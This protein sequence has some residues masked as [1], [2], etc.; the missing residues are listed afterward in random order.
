LSSPTRFFGSKSAIL[1]LKQMRALHSPVPVIVVS[2]L[3]DLAPVREQVLANGALALIPNPFPNPFDVG[4]LDRLVALALS[5]DEGRP[6]E[7]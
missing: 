5:H 4:E 1:F 7:G 3:A 6:V 2:D